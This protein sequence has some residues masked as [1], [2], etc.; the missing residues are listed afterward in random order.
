MKA[1]VWTDALQTVLMFGGMIIVVV[2]GTIA[3]GGVDIV[4]ER[5]EMSDRIEFF[6]YEN[7]KNINLKWVKSGSNPRK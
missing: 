6:K 5:S 2:V 4:W 7:T 3:V 1:V